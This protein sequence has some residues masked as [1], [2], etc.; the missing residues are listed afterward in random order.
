M[1]RTFLRAALA[2][3]LLSVAVPAHAEIIDREVFGSWVAWFYEVL[4][5]PYFREKWGA[6]YCDNYT[7]EIREIFDM[8]CAQLRWD[9]DDDKVMRKAFYKGVG[10]ILDCNIIRN[11]NVEAGGSRLATARAEA[12]AGNNG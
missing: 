2:G 3:L 11:W 8:G 5:S 12:Q 4:E 10:D 9:E 6:E 7:A 1:T